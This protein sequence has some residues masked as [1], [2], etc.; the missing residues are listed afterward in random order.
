[1]LTYI[2]LTSYVFFNLFISIMLSDFESISQKRSNSVEQFKS[3]LKIFNASWNVF[4]K[5]YKGQKIHQKKLIPFFMSL[6]PPLGPEP[7]L[8]K[9]QMQQQIMKMKLYGDVKG[10]IY[11]NELL[12]VT[13]K[14]SLRNEIQNKSNKQLLAYIALEEQQTQNALIKK[15]KELVQAQPPV[16]QP[17]PSCARA[18]LS[19]PMHR[20]SQRHAQPCT[21]ALKSRRGY[22]SPTSR[23]A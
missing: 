22:C 11:Y 9:L 5:K 2:I 3:S 7:S 15:H 10:F 16:G 21:L 12:F 19:A 23:Q 18:H 8:T 14:R 20:S 6:S 17:P 4:S 13:L 1:M